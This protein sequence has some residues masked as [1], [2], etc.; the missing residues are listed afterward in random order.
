LR[1]AQ[2]VANSYYQRVA[3][4]APD[5]NVVAVEDVK[6]DIPEE[7]T[8]DSILAELD[9]FIGMENIKSTVRELIDQVRL[10]QERARRGLAKDEKVCIHLVLTGNPGTG[11]T[12]VARK[13]GEVFQAIGFLDRGHV[14]EVD[15]G[16]LVGQFVGETPKLVAKYCDDAM[17]G[18]LFIDEAYALAPDTPGSTDPY[19]KEAIETLLKRMEDDRGKFVVV[20]AGYKDQMARFPNAN[21]GLKSRFD[22]ELHFEDYKPDELLAIFRLMATSKKYQ[23]SPE[24]ENRLAVAFKDM[25]QR[26]DKDF[27]NGRDVRKLFEETVRRLSSRVSAQLGTVTDDTALMTIQAEDIAYELRGK[28]ELSLDEVLGRLD[29]LIGLTAVKVEVRRIVD[30]LKVEQARAATGGKTTPLNLHFVFRGNPGTGKTTVARVLADV[31]K[32]LGLLSRGHLVEVERSGLVGQYVGQTAPKTN[33]VIDSAL[34]GVL[35][36][37]EAYTLSYSTSGSDFGREAI[38]VLLKR[39]EDDRG[40]FIV[41]AAGYSDEMDQFVNSNPGLVSRF[42]KHV[43]FDDYTPDEMKGIFRSMAEAK[44]MVLD[45]GVEPVLDASFQRLYATR[46]RSFAN[47]RTVRNLFE[48]A[49]QNQA[50]R[51]AGLVS[52]G[53]V[54]ADVLTLI[55]ADDI[56]SLTA[57]GRK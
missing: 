47:G 4:G 41:I 6:G 51:V 20:A 9:S 17:G 10:Q 23:L 22:R 29:R 53:N 11:K 55:N 36:I 37:D 33:A 13:L 7:K 43:D 44:G 38:D 42:T 26:R 32:A 46:D 15:R 57:G 56:A 16:K 19:G 35:F 28:Q 24:A 34:G 12:T 8:A 49:L 1:Q 48:A 30:Y 40:K 25:Y 2:N 14:V 18:I 5:D 27:G 31:F 45:P 21:P 39:M 50:G 54:N 3:A 52:A